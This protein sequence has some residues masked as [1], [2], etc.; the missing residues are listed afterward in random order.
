MT[1]SVRNSLTCALI[2]TAL[3]G[4]RSQPPEN[5]PPPPV[6]SEIY[7]PPDRRLAPPIQSTVVPGSQ[8]DF[9]ANVESDRIFFG[10]DQYNIDQSDRKTLQNHAQWLR[11]HPYVR[12]IIA[13]HA[14]ERGTR[15]YNLA[16]G[17]RRANAARNYLV[18]L[19]INPS[20]INVISYGKERPEVLGS[21]ERAW[22]QNRRAVTIIV[23]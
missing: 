15:D 4:C 14:D 11:R 1:I 19:G 9:L 3:V 21:N 18:T 23:Q 12:V 7:A 22:A 13:G 17:D 10:L 5:L 2:I 16:L 8:Q 20:R 6:G